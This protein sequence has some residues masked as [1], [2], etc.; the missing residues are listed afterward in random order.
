MFAKSRFERLSQLAG[1]FR[2]AT[3]ALLFMIGTDKKMRLVLR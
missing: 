2:G 3:L 1:I